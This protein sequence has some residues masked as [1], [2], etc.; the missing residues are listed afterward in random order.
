MLKPVMQS[1]RALQ[2]LI[3][4]LY[5]SYM[6]VLRIKVALKSYF[7]FVTDLA[8]KTS[9]FLPNQINITFCKLIMRFAMP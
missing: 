1:A 8:G 3:L 4:V 6:L 2:V 9:V 7:E 5:L